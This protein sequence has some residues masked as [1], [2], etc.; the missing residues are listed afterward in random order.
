MTGAAP[1]VV[2]LPWV[3]VPAPLSETRPLARLPEALIEPP[4][5]LVKLA[6]LLTASTIPSATLTAP[7]LSRVVPL[8]V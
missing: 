7:L 5:S 4:L 6:P 8:P 1:A 3:N 2:P